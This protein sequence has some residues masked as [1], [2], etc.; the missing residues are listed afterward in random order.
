MICSAA[1]IYCR[2]ASVKPMGMV[3]RSNS[4]LPTRSSAFL[5]IRLSEGWEIYSFCAAREKL[6]S[7]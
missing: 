2:P 3:L 5:I 1:R 7:R 6:R 4:G